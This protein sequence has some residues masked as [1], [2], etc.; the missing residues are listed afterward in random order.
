MAYVSSFRI[1]TPVSV[2]GVVWIQIL[3]PPSPSMGSWEK[4]RSWGSR[5]Q[6]KGREGGR[7]GR[8]RSMDGDV[9]LGTVSRSWPF[10]PCSLCF[11]STRH[12]CLALDL[13][14][15]SRRTR[16]WNFWSCK[17]QWVS[18][19]LL[20]SSISSQ[21][22]KADTVFLNG[23]AGQRKWKSETRA[24]ACWRVMQRGSPCTRASHQWATPRHEVEQ[25]VTNPCSQIHIT[26]VI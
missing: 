12:F 8:E 20:F 2:C 5:L 24:H 18:L 1:F 22:W 26:L 4:N 3:L 7:Q 16:G 6:C 23:F 17:P 11:L 19:E 13:K 10:L 15:G 25:W 14:Q 21:G 9:N